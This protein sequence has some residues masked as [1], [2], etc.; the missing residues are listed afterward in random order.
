MKIKDIYPLHVW[1][2][3]NELGIEIEMEGE[4]LYD[5]NCKNWVIDGD[6]SL[7]GHGAEYVL[8]GPMTKQG[9]F[10]SVDVLY[11]QLEKRA[12]IAPSD[13]CGVHIHIN[14]QHMDIKKV[15]NYITLYLIFEDLLL[16][17]C[18]EDREGNLFC[19]RAKDAEWLLVSLIEDKKSFGKF[20]KTGHKGTFK[21]SAMNVAAL[22]YYGSLEF[23]SLRTP[24]SPSPIK[25]YVNLLLHLK[26][27]A[28]KATDTKDFIAGCSKR[29][30]IEWAREILGPYFNMLRH[31]NMDEMIIE[32]VRRAQALAYTPLKVI[33]RKQLEDAVNTTVWRDI[34]DIQIAP[35]GPAP[36][37]ERPRRLRGNEDEREIAHAER[38]REFNAQWRRINENREEEGG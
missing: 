19:L 36:Q 18:G 2:K 10:D 13:R 1:P 8:N 24:S 26:K 27:V 34:A 33:K 16:S 28:L 35:P 38:L 22:T 31:R 30:E 12:N 4:G 15:F 29:G 7:R 6:G 37:P 14:C 9:A 5:V 17:W 32:G 3:E 25:E 21:Y 20:Y 11:K 23:R